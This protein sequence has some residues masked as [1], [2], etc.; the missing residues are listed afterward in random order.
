MVASTLGGVDQG[1]YEVNTDGG[2]VRLGVGVV[3]ETQQQ[4]RFSNTRVTDEEKLEEVVVSVREREKN[5]Y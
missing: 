1:T 2:D 3:S 5:Q 4:T